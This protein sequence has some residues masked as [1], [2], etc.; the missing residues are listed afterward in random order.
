V[1]TQ[2]ANGNT[3][4][5]PNYDVRVTLTWSQFVKRASAEAADYLT[6]DDLASVLDRD[7]VRNIEVIGRNDTWDEELD[8]RSELEEMPEDTLVGPL[9]DAVD[10][11]YPLHDDLEEGGTMFD[12][13]SSTIVVVTAASEADIDDGLVRKSLP[14]RFSTE[15]LER[16]PVEPSGWT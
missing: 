1:R 6:S 3:F 4:E 14:A 8:P 7:S 5:M 2:R 9:F 10:V 12:T 13:T 15:G 11:D 16:G